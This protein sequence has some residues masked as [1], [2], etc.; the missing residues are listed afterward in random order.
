[1]R[2][3]FPRFRR[4]PVEVTA[5]MK[6]HALLGATVVL[7]LAL[8]LVAGRWVSGYFVRLELF[9]SLSP[10]VEL[11][12]LLALVL[13]AGATVALAGLGKHSLRQKTILAAIV[14]A[15]A[16]TPWLAPWRVKGFE[17]RMTQT[18]DA[19]WLMLADDARRLLRATTADSQLPRHPDHEW[20]RRHVAK[21]AEA[22]P[23]L[24][25]GEFPP[26]LFVSEDLVGVYWGSGLVGTLAVDIRSDPSGE[27]PA[28]GGQFRSKAAT[29]HIAITWE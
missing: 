16:S 28:A 23:V 19:E 4:G 22:H 7:L 21:L 14:L 2:A 8:A 18:S 10:F 1:M 6:P 3:P 9:G 24:R 15:V 29:A 12:A 13:F 25:L 20:N 11:G 17:H 27:P 5:P 26:K